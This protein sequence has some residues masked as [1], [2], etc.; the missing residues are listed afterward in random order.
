MRN[1]L[2]RGLIALAL[3]AT[4]LLSIATARAETVWFVVG[5]RERHHGD[6][7]LLPL[8]EPEHIAAARK[9]LR[10]GDASGVGRIA[11][12]RIAAG[13]DG[14]NRNWRADSRPL[15]SW[16][17]VEFE[18]FADTA[19]EVC[20]GW[21]EFVEQDVDAYIANTDGRL[22]F[23]GYSVA[24]ELAAAPSFVLGEHIDGAWF[25]P[26]TP[27]QG[28]FVDA[29]M[30]QDMLFLGWFTYAENAS[31]GA[32]VT[33]LRWYTAQ[34]PLGE[35][36]ASLSITRTTGGAFNAPRPV[37]NADAGSATL[38]FSDCNRAELEFAF[39]GGARGRIPLQRISPREGCVGR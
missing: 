8:S 37:Q 16:R 18:G 22:C 3:L 9:Y 30:A 6:A 36:S 17:V 24:E 25:D 34:G 13:G 29:L 4:I 2:R 32:P 31:P 5:E 11:S 10:E 28:L 7:Y 21:P 15:W 38:R 26:A 19:I 14:L 12:V 23:W 33:D 35:S 1:L 20:D 39:D 27:G